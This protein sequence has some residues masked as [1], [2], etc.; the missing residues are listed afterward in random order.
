MNLNHLYSSTLYFFYLAFIETYHL[1]EAGLA[2][3]FGL[4]GLAFLL[5]FLGGEPP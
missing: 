4:P 1:G 5:P 3:G 2:F